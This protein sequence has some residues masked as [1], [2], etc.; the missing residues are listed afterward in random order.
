MQLLIFSNILLGS[1]C[2][3]VKEFKWIRKKIIIYFILLNTYRCF[4]TNSLLNRLLLKFMYSQPLKIK[5]IKIV[6]NTQTTRSLLM[7][8]WGD[9][10]IS[11][12]LLYNFFQVK[13]STNVNYIFLKIYQSLTNIIKTIFTLQYCFLYLK[14]DGYDNRSCQL[15]SKRTTYLQFKTSENY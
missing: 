3:S 5:T 9:I 8:I 11:K 4:H 10:Y 12:F 15:N 1:Y 7:C 14:V 13:F 2:S 6:H